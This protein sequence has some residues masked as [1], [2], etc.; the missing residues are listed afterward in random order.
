MS[1][2]LQ[3]EFISDAYTSLLH[4]SGGGLYAN[5]PKRDVY[6]GSGNITGFTLS[7]T[8]VIANNVELP[9]QHV[10]SLDA[11]NNQVTSLIDMFFPVGSIQMT[12]DNI[13]PQTR[14]PGTKWESVATGRFVVGVGGQ[15]PSNDYGQYNTANNIGG[16]G[17]N[18]DGLDS[19]VSLVQDQMP[20]HTHVPNSINAQFG[21]V[22][23]WTT[24]EDV[25]GG[26]EGGAINQSVPN[27]GTESIDP[28][29]A[30]PAIQ[31]VAQKLSTVGTNQAF[32]I[33]PVSYG[34][35]IWRRVTLVAVV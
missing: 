22:V 29:Y 4:L 25:P 15:N 1:A 35:Y 28:I 11:V 34:A 2:S 27:T 31:P 24:S 20:A 19:H 23:T 10:D 3:N 32:S 12:M 17:P 6:D 16:M 5:P 14:L 7:G 9:E 21:N 8:K 33:S 30:F 26:G 18:H 13:N